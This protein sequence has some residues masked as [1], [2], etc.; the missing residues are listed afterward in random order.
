ERG[1]PALLVGVVHGVGGVGRVAGGGVDAAG[2]AH[3]ITGSGRDGVRVNPRRVFVGLPVGRVDRVDAPVL[4][5]ENFVG[6][7]RH[8]ECGHHIAARLGVG[9]VGEVLDDPAGGID[10][11]EAALV[12]VG[13]RLHDLAEHVRL[14]AAEPFAEV[15]LVGDGGAIAAGAGE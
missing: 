6:E 3:R 1:A 15:L 13:P 4:A 11:V 8:P 14:V 7:D 10:L 12:L 5:A 2:H 9:D